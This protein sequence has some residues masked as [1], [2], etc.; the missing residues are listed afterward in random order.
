MTNARL[1][2]FT[3]EL[4][5]AVRPTRLGCGDIWAGSSRTAGLLELPGLDAWVHSAPAGTS[6]AGGDV[7]YVSVCPN[8]IVSR[9]ALADVS[10]HGT[11][12]AA[13]GDTLRGLMHE[14][15]HA[16]EQRALMRDLNRAVHTELNEVHYATMVAVGWH[17]RRAVLV[18]SNAGHPPPL[19]Y[20]AARNAWSWL[21]TTDDPEQDRPVGV[22]LGLLADVEYGRVVVKPEPGDLVVLYSDGASEATNES[23]EELGRDG[24]L[25][26]VRGLD[27][28]SVESFGQELTSALRRFRGGVTASDDESIIVLQRRAPDAGYD[29]AIERGFQST[30]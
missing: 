23:A 3:G 5:D 17:G 10:G 21:D 27:R 12:V 1:R 30:E 19:W 20:R 15:L 26:M 13:L 28:R 6:E 16:L 18:L 24:L 2:P 8:C 7:H 29:A 22:P 4:S 9:V 11:A 14:Y 25:D